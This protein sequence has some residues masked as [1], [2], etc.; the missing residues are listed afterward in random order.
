[1]NQGS[2]K[3]DGSSEIHEMLSE[4]YFPEIVPGDPS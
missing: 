3:I 1:M 2:T 4:D